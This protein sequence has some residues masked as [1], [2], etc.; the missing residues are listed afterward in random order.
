M[1][2][3]RFH[4]RCSFQNYDVSKATGVENHPRQFFVQDLGPNLSYTFDGGLLG[5]LGEY[6]AGG[7]KA[8]RQNRRS[9]TYFGRP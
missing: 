2:Y 7:K 4:I 3:F 1:T 5:G 8:Q 9:L 6:R